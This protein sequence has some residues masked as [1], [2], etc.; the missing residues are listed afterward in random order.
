MPSVDMNKLCQ[1]S[2]WTGHARH[3]NE[4]GMPSIEMN[5]VC[6]ASKWNNTLWRYRGIPHKC[7]CALGHICEYLQYSREQTET[8]TIMSTFI[9]DTFISTHKKYLWQYTRTHTLK[10]RAYIHTCVYIHEPYIFIYKHICSWIP[11]IHESCF[12]MHTLKSYIC[13]H[14]S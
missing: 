1:A 10:K 11:H 3:R 14:R 8:R 13:I 4:Q 12:C 7:Y 9:N 2:T 5:R 6:Q